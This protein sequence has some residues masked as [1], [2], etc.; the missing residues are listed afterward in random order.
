MEEGHIDIGQLAKYIQWKMDEGD[1]S[2]RDAAREARVSAST[3]SRILQK[4]KS[5]PS[6]DMETLTKIIHWVDI[7]MDKIMGTSIGRHAERKE[8]R[9]TLEE[10]RVHLR[11]DKNLSPEAA[12]AI[13]HMIKVAYKQFAKTRRD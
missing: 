4:K 12:R 13:A 2:L 6:P 10:I 11:A 3:L 8:N 5:R 9:D 1:L 7:P